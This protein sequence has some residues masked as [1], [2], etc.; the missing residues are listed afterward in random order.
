MSMNNEAPNFFIW[1]AGCLQIQK[2]ISGVITNYK[3]KLTLLVLL[4]DPRYAGAGDL[5]LPRRK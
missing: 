3:F 5:G 2:N 4:Q 1:L